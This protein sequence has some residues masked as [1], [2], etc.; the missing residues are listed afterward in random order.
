MRQL[1]SAKWAQVVGALVEGS[2]IRAMVRMTGAAKNTVVK[3]LV[4]LGAAC[5]K[6]A[7]LHES[8]ALVHGSRALGEPRSTSWPSW[9]QQVHDL[10]MKSRVHPRLQSAAGAGGR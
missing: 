7:L 5:A 3:L 9:R 6:G 1:G 2:S 8:S 10:D 4:D